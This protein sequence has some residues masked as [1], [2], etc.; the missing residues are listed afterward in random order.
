[1]TKKSKRIVTVTTSEQFG[2]VR[3]LTQLEN[4]GGDYPGEHLYSTL[5]NMDNSDGRL[6][7]A[8]QVVNI[9]TKKMGIT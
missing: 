7:E 8:M 1:M 3:S 9:L 5:P 2:E 4:W 6:D